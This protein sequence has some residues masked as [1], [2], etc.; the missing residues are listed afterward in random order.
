MK[1]LAINKLIREVIEIFNIAGFILPPFAFWPPEGWK[2][3]GTVIVGEA[4]AINDDNQDN[5]FIDLP[6]FPSIIEDEETIHLL[7]TDYQSPENKTEQDGHK[8]N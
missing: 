3:K 4:S 5:F 2:L 8:S 6:Y 7:C 1:R